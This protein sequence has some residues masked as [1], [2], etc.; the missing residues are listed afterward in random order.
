MSETILSVPVV[1][2]DGPGSQILQALPH[3]VLRI[4]ASGRLSYVNAAAENFLALSAPVLCRMTIEE[5]LPEGNP[6][7]TVIA[8]VLSAGVS[9][10]EYEIE[11][12]TPR[13]APQLVDVQ[14]I[15]SATGGTDNTGTI[16]VMIQKR[17]IA[18]QIDRQLTHRAAARSVMG[19][20]AMLAHEIKNP[21]A[22]I[23]GAA[24]L[25]ETSVSPL[26]A[27][28]TRLICE[29]TD[30][31]AS[32]VDRM[33]VF[34]DHRPT[35]RDLVNIHDVLDHV[36]RLV[37]SGWGD[38][39]TIDV[40]YDPSLPPLSGNR[41][42]LIQVFLNL[43]KNAVEA[44][45]G[46]TGATLTFAT[47]YRPGVRMQ[48]PGATDRVDLPLEVTI[49]DNGPGILP[50]LKDHLFDPFISSKQN[51]TGLGLALVAKIIGDHG[52]I[53]ESSAK[54][55]LTSFRARLPILREPFG[56]AQNDE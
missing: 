36:R 48:I 8:H 12:S 40:V 15:S 29:E 55:G 41:D 25:L 49:T 1:D 30:R 34:T 6:L 5:L 18:Q 51:G 23:K 43:A 42:Q 2:V 20:S 37:E 16:I 52:G 7:R 31:I 46:Q 39:V 50:D 56:E 17:A 9:V 45:E 22:G 44:M 26:D 35:S 4:E 14:V 19:V 38:Q 47:A 10:S 21:L 28:L 24:Q 3:P 53:I 33:E 11:L 13:S 27:E 54:D 32:L